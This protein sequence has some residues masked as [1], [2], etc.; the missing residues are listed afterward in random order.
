[1]DVANR[2]GLFEHQEISQPTDGGRPNTGQSPG[3]P[4]ACTG[5]QD[6]TGRLLLPRGPK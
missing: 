3:R 6:P 4:S 1:V 5:W 2:D